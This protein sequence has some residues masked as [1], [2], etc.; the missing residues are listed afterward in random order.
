M[1]TTVGPS[2]CATG[3]RHE[4]TG[5]AVDQHRA[6]AALAFA[7]AFLRTGQAEILAQHIQQTRHRMRVDVNLGA[8]QSEA[9]VDEHA[10]EW[11]EP[12]ERRGQ[13]DEAR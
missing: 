4:Q 8:V 13:S 1:L 6:R 12:L 10:R 9:H 7:A 11:P 3:T 5:C 2:A